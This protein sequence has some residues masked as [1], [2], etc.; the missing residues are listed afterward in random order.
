MFTTP[1]RAVCRNAQTTDKLTR[2]TVE[3]R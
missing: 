3:K 2:T 1:H